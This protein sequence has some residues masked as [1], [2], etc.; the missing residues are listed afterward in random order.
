MKQLVCFRCRKPG[1]CAMVYRSPA[2]V[3][4]VAESDIPVDLAVQPTRGQLVGVGR[5]TGRRR[6]NVP[7][8]TTRSSSPAASHLQLYATTSSNEKRLNV[9]SVHVDGATRPLRA[10]MNSGA[11]TTLLAPT[12]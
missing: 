9:L 2:S 4:A 10:L 7:K 3:L 8:V 11:K 5:P 6:R 1:H 12:G